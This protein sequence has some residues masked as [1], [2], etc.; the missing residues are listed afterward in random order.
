MQTQLLFLMNLFYLVQ[1]DKAS[2][3]GDTIEY[4]K[5]LQRRVQELETQNTEIKG[6]QDSGS[7]KE[8]DVGDRQQLD[9]IHITGQ[10]T[11]VP[12]GVE[13]GRSLSEG[14]VVEV[15]VDQHMSTV[16]IHCRWR[17]SLLIDILHNLI[18]LQFEVVEVQALRSNGMLDATLRAKVGV[19]FKLWSKFSPIDYKFILLR[20]PR[21]TSF[22][23]V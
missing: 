5:E 20:P 18:D 2:I 11:T 10:E 1:A 14:A 9:T 19:I 12:G 13:S 7:Q 21:T 23:F 4:V 17:R 22:I 3:L 15:T 8:K 6:R 16:R